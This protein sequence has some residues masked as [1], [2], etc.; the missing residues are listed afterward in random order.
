MTTRATLAAATTAT[1]TTCIMAAAGRTS[2]SI[3]ID[4]LM[5]VGVPWYWCS[6]VTKEKK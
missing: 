5:G 3:L 1:V 6:S 4:G 2:Q